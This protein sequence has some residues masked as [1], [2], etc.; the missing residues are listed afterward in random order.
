ML[1]QLPD[2]RPHF[3]DLPDPRRETRNKPRALQDILMIVLH[4]IQSGVEDWV[5][6]DAFAEEKEAWPRAKVKLTCDQCANAS[7][8]NL[9]PVTDPPCQRQ[10]GGEF[11]SMWRTNVR[12]GYPRAGQPS[13]SIPLLG[14]GKARLS[15]PPPAGGGAGDSTNDATVGSA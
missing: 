13:R 15:Q 10:R 11:P 7:P 3:A 9:D 1:P 6:M 2:P 8:L 5:G 4:T 14:S 12:A